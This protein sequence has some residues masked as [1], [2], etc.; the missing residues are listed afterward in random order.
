MSSSCNTTQS[1]AACKNCGEPEW[2]EVFVACPPCGLG[3]IYHTTHIN[4]E[5]QTPTP[6]NACNGPRAVE[7]VS[8]CTPCECNA[9]RKRCRFQ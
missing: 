2:V 5:I 3:E 4:Y 9:N 8:T 7:T 6:C 1:V